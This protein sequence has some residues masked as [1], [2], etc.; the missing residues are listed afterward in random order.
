MCYGS[1]TIFEGEGDLFLKLMLYYQST[2]ASPVHFVIKLSS[3]DVSN[4]PWKHSTQN[5]SELERTVG[6]Q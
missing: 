4:V 5:G 2:P 1:V 6:V 3:R